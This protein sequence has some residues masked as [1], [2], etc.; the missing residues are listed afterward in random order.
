MKTSKLLVVIATI[1]LILTTPFLLHASRGIRVEPISPTGERV[2]GNQWLFVIGIDTYIEW[3]R[4]ETAVNDAKSVKN[5]LLSRYHFNSDHL[6]ELYDEDATRANILS[7]LRYLA[8]N[9]VEDDSLFIFYA[10]HGHLDPITKSGSWIPVESGTKDVSAWI[11]NNDIKNYLRID[12]IKAKHILLVSDSCFSGDFFRGHRGKLPEVTNAVIKK[13]YTLSSR[14]AITSGGLE[15]VTDAGFGNNSVFSH[16]L[17]K[18]LEEN[19]DPFLVPS[20]FFSSIRAGVAENAEQFPQFGSLK[21][22]GGQQGGELVLF[23]KQDARL[24]DLSDITNKKLKKIERLQQMELEAK[25]AR[26]KEAEEISKREKD[27]AELDAKIEAMKNRLGT[28]VVSTDDSL[29]NMLAMVKQK[30]VQKKRLDELRR[31]K[32]ED[33]RKRNDEIAKLRKEREDK[34]ITALIP[35]VEKYKK[36]ISSE[37][38]KSMKS[39]SWQSLIAKCPPGWADGVDEGNTQSLLWTPVERR[40]R[41]KELRIQKEKQK[42]L[43]A[44]RGKEIDS[45]GRFIAYA[46]G[47]VYDKNTNLEWLAGP[48]TRTTWKEANKWV[49]NLTI[50]GGGWRMPTMEELKTIYQKGAGRHNMTPLLKTEGMYVYTDIEKGSPLDRLVYFGGVGEKFA[51]LI[52]DEHWW[53][54]G[55]AVRSRR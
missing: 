3:P 47:V 10:G 45:D 4:L 33:E 20:A 2:T 6:I 55:F 41:L 40:L 23:L 29:D 11:S 13:A 26:R 12:A 7:K 31:Q 28:S 32:E 46:T 16:F 15:P 49:A 25:K 53:A 27:L 9:I 50:A 34:I 5:V 44:I 14:Q 17:V 52:L 36:I 48:D 54:R 1:S 8:R 35:E 51:G 21:D 38:G 22:T 39:E 18:T 30:E 43:E 24:Q 37:F 42:A 19:K